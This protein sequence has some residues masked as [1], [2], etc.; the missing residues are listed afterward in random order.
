MVTKLLTVPQPNE[1]VLQ[2][3]QFPKLREDQTL[4]D[5]VGEIAGFIPCS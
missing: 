4:V 5:L 3:P 1:F 2:L